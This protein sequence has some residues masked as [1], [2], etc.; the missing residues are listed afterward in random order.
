VRSRRLAVAA[1]IV[2]L[3]ALLFSSSAQACSCARV[4]PEEALRLADAAIV[5]KL[6]EVIPRGDLRADYLYRVQRV[7]K[8]GQGIRRGGTISVRSATSSAACGLPAR[9]ERRYGVLLGR[10]EGHWTSGLCGLLSPELMR[11][12]SCA[13]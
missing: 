12:A 11:R 3:G 5:G 6:V 8:S 7:Y 2:G 4:A 10:A 1:A 9:T 13:S